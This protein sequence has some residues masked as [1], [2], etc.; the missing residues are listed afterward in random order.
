MTKNTHKP[1]YKEIG[2]HFTNF[3]T[4]SKILRYNYMFHKDMSERLEHFLKNNFQNKSF[5]F[6][7][8]GCG[9]ASYI[10]KVLNHTNISSYTALEVS[11]E[12]IENAKHNL[13]RINCLKNLIASDASKKFPN[14]DKGFDIIWSSYAMHHFNFKE[15]ES[16]F[17]QCLNYLKEKSC[18]IIVDLI[19]N[20]Q[21]REECIISLKKYWEEK[22]VNLD[23]DDLNFLI[24]HVSTSDYPET[25]EKLFEI[26]KSI[27]FKH[28]E[29]DYKIDHYAFMVFKK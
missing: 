27:G 10:S 19:N 29:L 26:A 17:E 25:I 23:Q 9:D 14:L 11:Q 15:K 2:K 5:D 24:E 6:L 7:D 16:F 18:L 3:N 12:A 4:Y 22:W 28:S 8:I 20:Y 13:G 1:S 21:N